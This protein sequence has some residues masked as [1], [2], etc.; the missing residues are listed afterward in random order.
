MLCTFFIF[1]FF[2]PA[3]FLIYRSERDSFFKIRIKSHNFSMLQSGL[4]NSDHFNETMLKMSLNFKCFEIQKIASTNQVRK[5]N[6]QMHFGPQKYVLWN[7]LR[8]SLILVRQVFVGRINKYGMFVVGVAAEN[9]NW[10]NKSLKKSI[11][12]NNGKSIWFV[13]DA[14]KSCFASASYI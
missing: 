4:M 10:I 1:S 5:R 12:A 14:I 9:W 2:F 3:Q 6:N 7:Y 8:G 11:C 13:E